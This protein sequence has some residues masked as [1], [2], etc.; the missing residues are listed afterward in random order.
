MALN[1][2]I[3]KKEITV[4]TCVTKFRVYFS[5]CSCVKRGGCDSF[6][7]HGSKRKPLSFGW[8]SKSLPQIYWRCN[9]SR[10]DYLAYYPLTQYVQCFLPFVWMASAGLV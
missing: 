5:A 4:E 10:R 8:I 7:L 9:N 6:A 3:T 1:G 2:D